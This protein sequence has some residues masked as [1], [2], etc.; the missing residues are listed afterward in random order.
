MLTEGEV[1]SPWYAKKTSDPELGLRTI[2][3][4][5]GAIFFFSDKNRDNPI[6]QYGDLH[7][8]GTDIGI[9]Y[10]IDDILDKGY[11][12]GTKNGTDSKSEV[13][14]TNTPKAFE[15]NDLEPLQRRE[16]AIED[17]TGLSLKDA[18]IRIGNADVY[19]ETINLLKGKG[20]SDEWIRERVT[21][22]DNRD[23]HPRPFVE[24]LKS[25]PYA[26]RPERQNE[27]FTPTEGWKHNYFI[28]NQTIPENKIV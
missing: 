11:T 28:W 17:T 14:V 4:D 20:F 15:K 27:K 22:L 10:R 19:T 2:E 8:G 13:F 18:Y 25:R 16:L 12:I 23:Q 7:R 9:I 5:P 21:Y 26:P 1:K 24:W 3:I 6:G